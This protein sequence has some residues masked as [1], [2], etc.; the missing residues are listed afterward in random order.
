[1]PIEINS[2]P[3]CNYS[4]KLLLKNGKYHPL[5][6]FPPFFPSSCVSVSH[7]G[8]TCPIFSRVLSVSWAQDVSISYPVSPLVLWRYTSQRQFHNFICSTSNEFILIA[9]VFWWRKENI[10]FMLFFSLSPTLLNILGA[11]WTCCCISCKNIFFPPQLSNED[12]SLL[13]L[14]TGREKCWIYENIFL[15]F[16]SPTTSRHDILIQG[17]SFWTPETTETVYSC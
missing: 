14:E 7:P 1:M 2:M 5:S 9:K 11:S 12:I 13:R 17:T 4:L 10:N 3:K 6:P 8:G 15:I 16:H